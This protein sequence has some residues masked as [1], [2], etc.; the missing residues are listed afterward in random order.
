MNL[1]FEKI[2]IVGESAGGNLIYGITNLA[3]Q[4]GVR[5]PDGVI[6]INPSLA[7]SPYHFSPSILLSLDD[8]FLHCKFLQR[9]LE[10]YLTEEMSHILDSHLL[11]P[12][13]TD[14]EILK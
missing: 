14:D 5:V 12:L 6:G 3:I 11:S 7:I 13:F 4:T 10:A 8:E 9:V 1:N 2:I